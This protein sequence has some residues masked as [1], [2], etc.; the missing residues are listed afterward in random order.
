M[1]LYRSNLD[2]MPFSNTSPTFQKVNTAKLKRAISVTAIDRL[3]FLG[4]FR[5]ELFHMVGNFIGFYHNNRGA[6]VCM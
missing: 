5:L 3:E 4:L 1:E 2:A 6:H